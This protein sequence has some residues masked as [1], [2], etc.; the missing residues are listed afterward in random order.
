M[1]KGEGER[2]RE[3]ERQR[4]L[5][6][7]RTQ[8]HPIRVSF[9]LIYL[10]KTFSPDTVALRLELQQYE[11]WWGDTIQPI[12]IPQKALGPDKHSSKSCLALS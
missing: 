1:R 10:L 5:L 2:G 12:A 8:F 6:F 7:I 9:N 3:K 4:I 11:F